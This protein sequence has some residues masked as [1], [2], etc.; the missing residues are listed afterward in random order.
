MC[1]E[2]VIREVVVWIFLRIDVFFFIREFVFGVK[3]IL[4]FREVLEVS[5]SFWVLG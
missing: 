5:C 2:F 3:L 4:C 1:E